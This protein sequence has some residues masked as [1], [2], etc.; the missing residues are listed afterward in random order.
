[1]LCFAR[2]GTIYTILKNVKNTHGGMLLLIKLSF[3]HWCFSHFLNCTNGIKLGKPSQIFCQFAFQ[4]AEMETILGDIDRAR[5][6]YELAINQSLLDMPEVCKNNGP[7][8]ERCSMGGY[9]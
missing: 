2:F 6:I 9:L 4:Y 8:L 5:A 3:L 1:M 7:F